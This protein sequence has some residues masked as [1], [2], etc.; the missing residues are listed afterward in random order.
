VRHALVSGTSSGIGAAIARRLLEDGWRVTGLDVAPPPIV[1]EA[2]QARIVDL[3]DAAQCR[4]VLEAVEP[5]EAL[6][7]AAGL[8]RVGTLGTLDDTIGDLL[9][10]VHVDA[11]MVL[12]DRLV[13]HMPQGGRI[14]L[15]GSHAARGV[16][17]RSQYAASKAALHALARSWAAE[18]IERGITVNVVS[19]AT[20]D[21]PMLRDPARAAVPPVMPAIGRYV[22]PEE[23]AALVAFLLS[24]SA[25]AITG[26]D[27]LICGGASLRG[28]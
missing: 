10:R 26:Q 4:A 18:L 12:A 2:F 22:K 24:D 28:Q 17:G 11:A 6:V 27:I 25:A 5:A 15:I 14:V 3:A 19:P 9:W 21:T 20:T 16:P 13:S 7:H 8:M 23:V 1:A